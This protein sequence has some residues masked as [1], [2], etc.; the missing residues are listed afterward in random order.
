[1]YLYFFTIGVVMANCFASPISDAQYDIYQISG[2]PR[3]YQSSPYQ[4]NACKDVFKSKYRGASCILYD[5]ENCDGEEG[6]KEMAQGDFLMSSLGFDVE[7]V[8]VRKG[9]FLNLY[10]GTRLTGDNYLLFDSNDDM[11]INMDDNE[12][13]EKFDDNV[14]SASCIC[15]PPVR[16]Y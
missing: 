1:M 4:G 12:K 16:N 9:C 3:P 15:V 8:S 14:N 5:D 6:M 11:H 7:S 10:T 2:L 13:L